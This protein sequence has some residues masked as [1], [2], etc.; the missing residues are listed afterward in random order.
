M[1]GFLEFF[2]STGF[3]SGK[4]IGDHVGTACLGG[5]G[6][7]GGFIVAG[8]HH[9]VKMIFLH[10]FH[11]C[12]GIGFQHVCCGNGSQVLAPFIGKVQ[13]SFAFRSQFRQFRNRNTN[14]L[15]ET[16][17]AA[18]T[19]DTVYLARHAPAWKGLKIKSIG[20]IMVSPM[21]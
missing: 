9:H 21:G 14:L 12:H 1:S 10:G 13:G 3:I 5:N 17:V 7:C 4:H 16:S 15:H 6:F 8:E 19:A 20:I 11:R 2:H 18:E